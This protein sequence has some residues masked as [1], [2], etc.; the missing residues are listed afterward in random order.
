MNTSDFMTS[1]FETHSSGDDG[2]FEKNATTMIVTYAAE[3]MKTAAK[4]LSHGSRNVVTPEDIKRSMMLEMFLFNKRTNLLEIAAEIRKE[5]YNEGD[6][7][8]NNEFIIEGEEK[9]EDK[10]KE[11]ECDCA[12]C[13]CLNTIYTKWETFEP[14]TMFEKVFKKHIDNMN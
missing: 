14:E 3:A 7:E 10:F 6:E 1:E 13:N 8:D 11:N 5:I 12:M 4:Y 2:D 9:T